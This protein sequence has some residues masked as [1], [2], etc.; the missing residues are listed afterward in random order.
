M[1]EH[2]KL[3]IRNPTVDWTPTANYAT[4]DIH[5]HRLPS[6]FVRQ[7]SM[8]QAHTPA[9]DRRL[10]VDRPCEVITETTVIQATFVLRRVLKTLHQCSSEL[11]SYIEQC[12]FS[13][14]C[15]KSH[16]LFCKILVRV[17]YPY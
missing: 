7:N 9:L 17:W 11:S 10:P 2:D 4:L 13:K 15:S 8:Y 6:Q 14:S 12:Y 3:H 5:H 16:P 1:C